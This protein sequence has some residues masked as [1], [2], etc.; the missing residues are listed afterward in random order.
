MTTLPDPTPNGAACTDPSMQD[1]RQHDDEAVLLGDAPAIAVWR[2]D[3]RDHACSAPPRS[4]LASRLAQR[5]VHV[6]TRRGDVIVDFDSDPNLEEVS[7]SES[8]MYLSINDPSAAAEIAVDASLVFLGWSTPSAVAT[9][10]SIAD[11]IGACQLILNANTCAV[12]AV[13]AALPGRPGPT[14][15]DHLDEILPAVR[16]A[17]MT[18]ALHIVAIIGAWD[19][20][21]FLYYATPVEVEAARHVR[22]G[23][24]HGLSDHIDLLVFTVGKPSINGVTGGGNAGFGY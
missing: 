9:P 18:C 24:I 16:A 3:D 19:R 1:A 12:A 23:T 2:L 5:L 14:F 17:G 21:E 4:G 15:A 13:R 8:R 22:A 11:R 7:G 10:A 20:D 6:Y